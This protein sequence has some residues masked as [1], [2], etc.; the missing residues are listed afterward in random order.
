MGRDRITGSIDDRWASLRDRPDGIIEHR[1]GKF[2]QLIVLKDGD[3]VILCFAGRDAPLTNE[4]LSGIM[5]RIDISDPLT[6]IGVYTQAMLASLAFMAT[7][8]AAYVMGTGGGRIPMVLQSLVPD[9]DIVGSDLDPDV[10]D[11]SKRWF[12]FGD[13]PRQTIACADGRGHLAAQPDGR[14]DHLYLDCFGADGRVP[15]ALSTVEF[16]RMCR[17][18]LS[19]RGVAC[20]NLIE[21]DALFPAQAG[22][23]CRAFGT[24]RA[25]RHDGT[26]VLFGTGAAVPAPDDL[27]GAAQTLADRHGLRFDF[28]AHVARFEPVPGA[29]VGDVLHDA[30][31][32]DP[33]QASRFF[34]PGHF[35]VYRRNDPCP[36]G[37]GRK[38][39]L[40]HGR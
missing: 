25:F 19:P 4:T 7:P 34:A 5:A 30:E 36:C 29:F 23:F 1:H 17:D 9:V 32:F 8:R 10:L 2:A 37:S 40:C 14:F 33:A 27:T 16:F 35:T 18:R 12:G 31:V 24:V 39:K 38:F 3:Q 6:L 22:G 13:G 20:M 21:G 26:C 11:I 28:A 15:P